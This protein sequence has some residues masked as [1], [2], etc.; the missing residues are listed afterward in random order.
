MKKGA[1]K[2]K[3]NS[4][5]ISRIINESMN[6][7]SQ[8]GC[9][10]MS[11]II[12]LRGAS[13]YIQ[14]MNT[15]KKSKYRRFVSLMNKYFKNCDS[16]KRF[17]SARAG[18]ASGLPT[19]LAIFRILSL[20]FVYIYLM[21]ISGFKL[22]YTFANVQKIKF[23]QSVKREATGT[24]GFYCTPTD[25][26]KTC[27]YLKTFLT[28]IICVS[29]VFIP[30]TLFITYGSLQGIM[31]AGAAAVMQ[32]IS[33][34][35]A[36]VSVVACFYFPAHMSIR[37]D[38]EYT[39]PFYEK[40]MHDDK[41]AIVSQNDF[42]QADLMRMNPKSFYSTRYAGEFNTFRQSEYYA[43]AFSWVGGKTKIMKALMNNPHTA[44]Q[45]R[46]DSTAHEF[47]GTFNTKNGYVLVS[48]TEPVETKNDRL[49]YQQYA[50]I[51]ARI[52]PY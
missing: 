20:P 13:P 12:E 3:K 32:T 46:V 14:K 29:I 42:E 2:I 40:L 47:A 44:K 36:Q 16:A 35:I 11:K 10:N 26:E 6:H 21:F 1:C 45:D 17:N 49:L 24:A 22:L 41:G 52:Q 4:H 38:C 7:S 27:P 51:K 23:V 39:L 25:D 43:L 33:T 15:D 9:A 8:K 34:V 5:N 19:P 31:Q 28:L 37:H 48:R 50:K 30:I 18:N